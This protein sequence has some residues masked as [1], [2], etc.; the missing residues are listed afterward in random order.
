[1]IKNRR[2]VALLIA[3]GTAAPAFAQFGSLGGLVG[4]GKP[5]GGGNF[6]A[7]F[8]ALSDRCFTLEKMAWQASL[9][10]A[11]A[12]TADKDKSK[13]EELF[14]EC[15]KQT[16]LNESGAVFQKCF[17]S[18]QG[19]MKSLS[20]ASDFSERA[21]TLSSEKFENLVKAG[22]NFTL[23][24]VIGIKVIP[25]DVQNLISSASMMDAPK[26]VGLKDSASRLK[27]AV[28]IGLP[29]F[30]KIIEA[31]KGANIKVKESTGTFKEETVEF[32]S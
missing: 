25:T 2:D 18:T 20:A 4:G 5:S 12:F 29:V 16:N 1:M 7:N 26:L 31:A 28:E 19:E 21:K 30:G 14:K 32:I 17:E 23:G 3:A 6:D 13:Y 10:A 27:N 22:F 8:K 15:G 24:V 11:A 9:L